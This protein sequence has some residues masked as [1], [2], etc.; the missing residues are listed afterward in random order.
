M[1]DYYSHYMEMATLS[2]T[3]AEEVINIMWNFPTFS[4]GPDLSQM[5]SSTGEEVKL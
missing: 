3:I 2:Q 5:A 1:I 4:Q